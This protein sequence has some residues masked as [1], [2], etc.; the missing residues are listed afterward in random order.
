MADRADYIWDSL[1]DQWDRYVQRGQIATLWD[2]YIEIASDLILQLFQANLSKS[3]RDIPVFR[4][5]RWLDYQ[6]NRTKAPPVTLLPFRFCYELYNSDILDIPRLHDQVRET[7]LEE[8]VQVTNGSNG[9]I[10]DGRRLIDSSGSTNFITS[11]VRAGDTIVFSSGIDLPEEDTDVRF[12]IDLVEAADTLVLAADNLSNSATAIRYIIQRSPIL[13]LLEGT[14]YL[15]GESTICFDNISLL[16]SAGTGDS[17][18]TVDQLSWEGGFVR[19]DPRTAGPYAVR[20]TAV[21][22]GNIIAGGRALLDSGA[23]YLADGVQRG[24]YLVLRPSGASPTQ[25][26]TER[27]VYRIVWAPLTGSDAGGRLEIEG[28]FSI[29]ANQLTYDI[30]RPSTD[31]FD[32]IQTENGTD[33]YP[34]AYAFQITDSD[35][36]ATTG[37]F[38]PGNLDILVDADFT[39]S[40]VGSPVRILS[41]DT[42][43]PSDLDI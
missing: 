2:G 34:R 18:R 33:D 37:S 8:F 17:W 11:G 19:D 24:D 13:T 14:H 5:Y 26:L 31:T 1:G 35:A 40:L 10:V 23:D 7:K 27:Q 16:N 38:A 15:A 28:T 9:F 4:R 22:S 12:R 32:L 39:D 29:T 3:I 25:V 30:L 6:L 36:K 21:S 43:A 41:G 42:L 20:P